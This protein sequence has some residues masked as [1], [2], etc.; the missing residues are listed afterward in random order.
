MR[1]GAAEGD[2]VAAVEIRV[3]GFEPWILRD[4]RPALIIDSVSF[5]SVA[6]FILAS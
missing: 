6:C 4:D 3:G 1:R 2:H 5:L